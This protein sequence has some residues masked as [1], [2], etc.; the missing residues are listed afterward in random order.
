MSTETRL[1]I[2]TALAQISRT[3]AINLKSRAKIDRSRLLVKQSAVR[4]EQRPTGNEM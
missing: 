1:L 3:K 2:A 4:C